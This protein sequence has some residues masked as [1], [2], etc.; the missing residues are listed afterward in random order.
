MKSASMVAVESSTSNAV[1]SEMDRRGGIGAWITATGSLHSRSRLPHARSPV[2]A[3][4][5]SRWRLPLPIWVTWSATQRLCRYSPC[6]DSASKAASSSVWSWLSPSCA[7]HSVIPG[8]APDAAAVAEACAPWARKP[9][10]MGVFL[11]MH[12]CRTWRTTSGS[13]IVPLMQCHKVSAPT[14]GAG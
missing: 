7:P 9:Q 6:S 1:H 13:G 3:A 11:Q 5:R 12:H 4:K 10:G 14:M 2:A 8:Y